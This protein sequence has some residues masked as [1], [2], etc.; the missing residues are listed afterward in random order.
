LT[1]RLPITPACLPAVSSQAGITDY[2]TD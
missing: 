1:H 2:C